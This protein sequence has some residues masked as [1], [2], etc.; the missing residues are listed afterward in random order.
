M[1]ELVRK[2]EHNGWAD[3]REHEYNNIDAELTN[4]MKQAEKDC[5]PKTTNTSM[6]S[7][8]LEVATR[9]IHSWN[10]RMLRR[11]AR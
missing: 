10:M 6:G 8:N 1:L 11:L 3:I 9:V 4:M 7:T 5:I 2:A